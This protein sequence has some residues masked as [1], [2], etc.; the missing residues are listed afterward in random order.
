VFPVLI[1]Q[2]GH[3]SRVFFIAFLFLF[4][5]SCASQQTPVYNND[6]YLGLLIGSDP[7]N[8]P[9]KIRLFEN[10]LLSENVYTRQAAAE[11]LA[12]LMTQGNELSSK[13]VTLVRREASH[14]WR[15]AF[16]V[17][18]QNSNAPVN[19]KNALSFLLEYD[20]DSSLSCGEA[21]AFVINECNKRSDF[22]SRE[23]Y[24]AIEAR[25][26][27]TR[28]SY[29]EALR[30]FRAFMETPGESVAANRVWPQVIPQFF[31]NYPNSINDLGRAFQYTST[32]AEG[33]NLFIQ[34]EA[35]LPSVVDGSSTDEI[36]YRLVFFAARIARRTGQGNL[37][38][39]L[40]D[41]ALFLAPDSE[42]IDACI[43]YLLDLALASNLSVTM[44]RLEKYCPYLQ[45]LN[46]IND[47]ME[48]HLHNLTASND[49]ANIIKTFGII[50]DA[51]GNG[52]KSGFA[53]VIA[54]A[55]Q[56]GYLSPQQR[57]TL[58]QFFNSEL[59]DMF[60]FLRIAY[61][62]SDTF[63]MPALYYRRQSAAAL[64]LPFFSFEEDSSDLEDAIS[65]LLDFILGFFKNEAAEF[66]VPYIRAHEERM[67]AGELRAAA[68][69]LEKA[70]NYFQSMRLAA[71]YVNRENYKKTRRDIELMFPRPH[72]ELI[73]TRALQFNIAPS[74]LYGLIRTE[75]AFQGAVVS[76][77]GAVGF[78]QLM[79]DTARD[80]A[81]RIRRSGGPNFFGADNVIDSTDID[82]N[83]YIGAYYYSYLFDRFNNDQ[84]ALMSYNGG[85]TRVQRWRNASALPADL[86]VETVTIYETRDF[87]RRVPAMG[88]VYQELYY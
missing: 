74:L 7:E 37:A 80:M 73:E 72:L 78:M 45:S 63:L 15:A 39:F 23:E 46:Y 24:A 47:L 33:L 20:Q 66:C 76:S 58:S 48:R 4:A 50:K 81:D 17:V 71:L 25:Y 88:S 32:G 64:K 6:F 69:A 10:A 65:P 29:N 44:E 70:G 19:K 41:K 35:N 61:N 11:Q 18:P 56:E 26:A 54:R 38:A 87:G 28:L 53:W 1:M 9:E 8:R 62:T 31:I 77:A 36:R 59:Y 12:I 22:F 40:F 13:T 79:P 27:I 30:S 21:R 14:W 52:L 82:T 42:Q 55:I 34:W 83:V 43:W 49:W 5:V 2:T 85:M 57:Q 75:S 3:F 51:K 60:S 16:D 86:L 68:D 84:L 67:S